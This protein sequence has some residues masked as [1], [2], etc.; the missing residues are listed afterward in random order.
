M[1]KGSYCV[2]F[3]VISLSVLFGAC[4]AAGLK[5]NFYKKS[6]PN[7]EK[8]VKNITQTRT[9]ADPDTAA[10]L[11]RLH[12]H[13]CFVRGCDAS[14]LLDTAA[15]ADPSEKQAFPNLSL[16]GFDVIDT[17]KTEVEKSCPGVVSCAD[18]LALSARDAVSFQVGT[19]IYSTDITS[20]LKIMHVSILTGVHGASSLILQFKKSMWE[21]LTG[22]K[23]GRVSLATEVIGNLPSPFSNFTTLQQL[24]ALKGFSV[25]DLVALSGAHTIGL[26]HCG[27]FRRR[28]NFTG[29][30]DV[31]PS[32]DSTYAQTLRSKC[33][34]SP[35]DPTTTVE[36]DPAG[37]VNFDSDYF[38]IL[39]QNKGLF[40]SDAALLTNS[41]SAKL[42]RQFQRQKNFLDQFAL[43]MKKMGAVEVLTDRAGEIRKQCRVVN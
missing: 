8:I 12:Y 40:Q 10:D 39:T 9:A 30:D 23:D 41:A 7:A 34:T 11:L 28:L 19:T 33:S 31:D 20:L 16:Q 2:L 3:L 6:C 14:V 36:M 1:K 25:K 43:S 24:F 32:L 5:A 4:N 37:S 29:N 26:A 21:V 42:V 38:L 15:G 13:D 27:A 18:I 35:P 22:R 17:I